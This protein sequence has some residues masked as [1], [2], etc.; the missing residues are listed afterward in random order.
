MLDQLVSGVC[1]LLSSPSEHPYSRFSAITLLIKLVEGFPDIPNFSDED[2]EGDEM[3]FLVKYSS[4]VVPSLLVALT[5]STSLPPIQTSA[6]HVITALFSNVKLEGVTQHVDE[7][8]TLFQCLMEVKL[9]L[10]NM[11]ML[12]C[13]QALISSV[14]AVAKACGEHF[15]RLN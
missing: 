9:D 11:P 8:L 7:L 15:I 10:T 1:S 5:S 13:L 14:G 6:A 12:W 2:D 3:S 4:S